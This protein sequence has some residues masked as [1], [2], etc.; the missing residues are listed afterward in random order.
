M[1]MTCSRSSSSSSRRLE[2]GC[3]HMLLVLKIAKPMALKARMCMSV[4]EMN[5]LMCFV[6]FEREDVFLALRDWTPHCRDG[7]IFLIQ[8]SVK[9]SRS[10]AAS[11]FSYA[12]GT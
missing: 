5:M 3:L 10:Q 8:R 2:R 7:I 11:L 12:P 9:A 1:R 4:D 6:V